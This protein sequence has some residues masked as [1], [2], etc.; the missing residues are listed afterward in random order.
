VVTCTCTGKIGVINQLKTQAQELVMLL[1]LR[2]E[3]TSR[4]TK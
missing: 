4:I 1:T 2:L 3:F